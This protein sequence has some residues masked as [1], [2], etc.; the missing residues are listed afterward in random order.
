MVTLVLPGIVRRTER[1]MQRATAVTGRNVAAMR[2]SSYWWVIFSGFFEPLLYLL[3][4]GVGVGALVGPLQLAN[5]RTVSYAE[6][7]AP[8]MLAAAAMNGAIAETTFNFFGKMKY[9]RLY[10]AVVATPVTPF[11]VALGEL[12]W[13]LLRGALYSTAFLVI[14]A[15]MGL[16]SPLGA[17][18]AFPATLLVGLAFGGLGMMLATFVR[19]WQDFDYVAVVQFAMFLF[20]GTFA[21]ADTFPVALRAVVQVFPL[22]HGVE[23]V[24]SATTGVL[25]W[26]ILWHV[27]YLVALTVA[28]LSVAA[29]RTGRLLYK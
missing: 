16:T 3:S 8:A 2:H 17:L 22:Y 28:G 4:I 7:I 11:E 14:M 18:A 29:R 25:S 24:R 20:S 10:D 19:S 26:S 23:L 13:G 1:R 15:A 5:G 6:F 21:P 12:L 27:A 9:M